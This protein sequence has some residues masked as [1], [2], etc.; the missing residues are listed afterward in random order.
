MEMN[1]FG[2]VEIQ[3]GTLNDFA[4]VSTKIAREQLNELAEILFLSIITL[5]RL[6]YAF[7]LHGLSLVNMDGSMVL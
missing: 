2:M 5:M 7:L 4:E 6:R 1:P 3:F